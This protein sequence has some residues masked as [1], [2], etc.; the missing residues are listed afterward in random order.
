MNIRKPVD[1]VFKAF[2]DP[3]ITSK[4]WFTKSSGKLESGKHIKWDWEM[5]EVST[6]V[7]VKLLEEN[8]RILIE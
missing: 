5:Y 8:K 2:V 7:Y 4:F 3:E 6:N 1:E